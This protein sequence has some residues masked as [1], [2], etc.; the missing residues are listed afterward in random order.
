[1]RVRWSG[2]AS[3][4]IALRAASMAAALAVPSAGTWLVRLG[5]FAGSPVIVIAVPGASRVMVGGGALR[6]RALSWF[7]VCPFWLRR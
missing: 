6:D 3:W 2:R 7:I 5:G 4:S 1:M